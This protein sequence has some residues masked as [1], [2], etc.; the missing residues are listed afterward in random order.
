MTEPALSLNAGDDD[1]MTATGLERGR[2]LAA[3]R[4]IADA[5][6]QQIHSGELK[7][8][9]Q[10]P[11]EAQLAARFG[12]NRHTVRRALAALGADGLVRS[13]QG[14]GAFVEAQKL[15]YPISARMRFT[16]NVGRTGHEAGGEMLSAIEAPA[17]EALAARLGVAPGSMVTE[18]RI[19]RFVDGVPVTVGTS[20]LPLPRFAD[21]ADAL[22]TSGSVTAALKVCG[23]ADYRRVG[24][25]ISA[26][27]ATP[28]EAALLDLAPG[29]VVLVVQGLN[30]DEA[31]VAIQATD[32][33]FAADRVQLTV[34]S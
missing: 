6:S 30:V 32:A 29:R 8:G 10:L 33:V 7:A 13:S 28:E 5:L 27:V 11:T 18:T 24:T 9:A 21:F 1:A 22:R 16:E 4:Q 15:P 23:V 34:G 26:R 12:V 3:W 31:G 20:R 14:R 17:S 25:D 19:R 2:G